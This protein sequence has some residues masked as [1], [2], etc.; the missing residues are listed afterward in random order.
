ME[1]SR[2]FTS[3]CKKTKIVQHLIQS[4]EVS[5]KYEPQ[6]SITISPNKNSKSSPYRKIE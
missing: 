6:T 2:G 1:I 3:L 5:K 4:E